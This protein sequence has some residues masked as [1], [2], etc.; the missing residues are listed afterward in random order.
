VIF[1]GR[2][3]GNFVNGWKEAGIK[4]ERESKKEEG[5][6]KKVEG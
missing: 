5:R 3:G 1:C 4:E 2:G 6:V